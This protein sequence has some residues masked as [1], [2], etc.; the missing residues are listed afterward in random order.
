SVAPGEEVLGLGVLEERILVP[1]KVPLA[2][3]GERRDPVRLVPIESE[4]QLDEPLQVLAG[5]DW[6]DFYGHGDAAPYTA[7]GRGRSLREGAQPRANRAAEG[8]AGARPAPILPPPGRACGPGRG[9][10][11]QGAR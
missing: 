8:C 9:D 3:V 4:R 11:R 5:A 2:L 1:V 7:P 6:T 10:G